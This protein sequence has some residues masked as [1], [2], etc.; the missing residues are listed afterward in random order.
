MKTIVDS[1]LVLV[2][3][4]SLSGC[5]GGGGGEKSGA[6]TTAQRPVGPN[7]NGRWTGTYTVMGDGRSDS[8]SLTATIRHTGTS[9]FL[10]TSLVGIGASFTGTINAAGDMYLTDAFDGE[11]WT[12]HFGPATTASVRIADFA[13]HPTLGEETPLEV[14]DLTR[15]GS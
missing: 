9:V 4:L 6:G 3:A 11:T 5:G 1:W 10:T 8:T 2:L 13:E 7:L 15:A 12:T 14:I